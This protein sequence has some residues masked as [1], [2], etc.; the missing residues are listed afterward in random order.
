M[1]AL[2]FLIGFLIPFAVGEAYLQVVDPYHYGEKEDWSQYGSK[3]LDPATGRLRP[4]AVAT[5]LGKKTIISSQGWR[6]PE[7]AVPKPAGVYRILL[8]GGSVP[9]GWGVEEGDEYPRLLERQLN[10]KKLTGARRIEVINAGVPGWK[11]RERLVLLEK[12]NEG[13]GWQP[14]MV[15]LTLVATDVPK[16]RDKGRRAFLF[17]ESA[18]RLRLARAVENRYVFHTP[19]TQGKPYDS[20]ADLP[21]EG[22]DQVNFA[23]GLFADRCEAANVKLVVFDT[24]NAKKVQARCED[25]RVLWIDGWTTWAMRRGWEVAV[26]DAHPNAEGHRELARLFMAGVSP[27]LFAK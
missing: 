20:Y 23:L 18:R 2:I 14:D 7:F 8:L 6:S 12:K 16:D 26:T 13:L 19:G 27:Q 4:N 10:A 24:L 11:L 21:D 22:L 3:V 15:I 17:D 5:Y 1:K 25:L 9:Y